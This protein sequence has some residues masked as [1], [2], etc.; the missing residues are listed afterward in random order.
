ME[1]SLI[2]MMIDDAFQIEFK[3]HIS[4]GMNKILS[5]IPDLSICTN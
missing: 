3:F 1:D 5:L 4:F 2:V